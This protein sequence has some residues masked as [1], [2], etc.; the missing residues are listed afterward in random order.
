[1]AIIRERDIW[2]AK[3]NIQ[4][5]ESVIPVTKTYVENATKESEKQYWEMILQIQE[6]S[7]EKDKQFVAQH[8]GE[9]AKR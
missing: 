5:M 6:D 9:L 3:R 7:L 8:E 2:Q 1:M 4:T